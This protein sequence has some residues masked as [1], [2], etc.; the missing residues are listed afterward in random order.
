MTDSIS[1]L[2]ELGQALQKLRGTSGA[3]T[4]AVAR[5]AGRSRDTLHRLEHGRDGSVSALLDI[6]RAQEC[7][8]QIVPRGFPSMAALRALL[9][10][11]EHEDEYVDE[12]AD[13]NADG[14]DK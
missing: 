2:Q 9:D 14:D 11:D 13:E 7:A 6:L 1:S 12:Q 5:D 4:V 8:L 10:E 3:K